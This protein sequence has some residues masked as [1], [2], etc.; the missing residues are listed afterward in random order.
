[1]AAPVVIFAYDRPVHLQRTINALKGNIG[2]NEAEVFI[3][4]DTSDAPERQDN[5]Q[6]VQE[7]LIELKKEQGFKNICVEYAQSHRGLANSVIYGVSKVIEE[8]GQV[9]VI[10]DDLITSIDFLDYMNKALEY[11]KNEKDIWSISGY[12]FPM[13]SLHTYPH[14]IFYS[15]RACSWGWATWKDRWETVDWNVGQ[16]SE[17]IKDKYWQKRFNQGGSDMTF[18]LKKQMDGEQD[19]WA[20]RW[21]FEQ[22]NQ[23]KYTIYPCISKVENIGCDGSGTHSGISHEYDV[24]IY[25]SVRPVQLEKLGPDAKIVRE[26]YLK[27]TDTFKKKLIRKLRSFFK[28]IKK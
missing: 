28:L 16:Y 24:K 7:Y 19:S 22:S 25:D 18:M 4:V 12:S 10:E 6:K 5:I 21:C 3:F 8:Y 2:A 20:I 17:F 9:I 13:K 15:Y 26:F 11:Y 14:D 1:M 27:Y 23:G